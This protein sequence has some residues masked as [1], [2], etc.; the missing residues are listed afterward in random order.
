[1][2]KETIELSGDHERTIEAYRYLL[3]LTGSDLVSL[4]PKTKPNESKI[5]QR[6]DDNRIFVRRVLRFVFPELYADE[7]NADKKKTKDD[8][9]PGISLG[10]LVKILASLQR[11]WNSQPLSLDSA[12]ANSISREKK[13]HLLNI[14][15]STTPKER[16]D[17]G[18][19]EHPGELLLKKILENASDPVKGLG[20]EEIKDIYQ[21]FLRQQHTINIYNQNQAQLSHDELIKYTIYEYFKNLQRNLSEKFL[22][23]KVAEYLPKVKREISRIELQSGLKQIDFI[24]KDKSENISKKYL[25]A[26]LIRRLTFLVIDNQIIND[27]FPVYLKYYHIEAIRPL[28]LYLHDEDQKKGLLNSE[29]LDEDED[30]ESI[31]GLERQFVYKATVHFYIRIDSN[32]NC[33]L[34]STEVNT[35]I[36][37]ENRLEFIE[38]ITGVGSPISLVI[39]AINRVLLRDIPA[40]KDYFYI[41]NNKTNTVE[42][43]GSPNNNL[44]WSHTLVEICKKKDIQESI[45]SGKPYDQISSNNTYAHGEYCG[46]D[47]V[48]IATKAALYARLKAIQKTGVSPK[49][50]LEQLCSRVEEDNAVSISKNLISY[51]PFSL[52]AMEGFLDECLL[53]KK[54]WKRD[55]NY[56]FITIAKPWSMVA[57]EAHLNITEAYL[58]EGLHRVAKKYLALMESH[59]ED[60][61][62]ENCYDIIS[63]LMFARY[64][65]CWFRYYYLSD[66][67]DENCQFTDR[68]HVIDKALYHL[69][70]AE[71]YLKVRIEKVHCIDQTEQ[72]NFSPF[73]S[74][75]SKIYEYRA[76]IYM[77]FNPYAPKDISKSDNQ[78][79]SFYIKPI[80]LFE[81]ARI[82]AARDGNPDAYSYNSVYQS[83]CYLRLA[84]D[85][86]GNEKI[87][88][89][90]VDWAERLIEHAKLCYSTTGKKCYQDIKNHSGEIDVS[91]EID[92][93]KD[94]DQ[95]EYDSRPKIKIKGLPIIQ[96]LQPSDDKN[97]I[98]DTKYDVIHPDF[99]LLKDIHPNNESKSIY[100]F[101]PHSSVILFSMGLVDLCKQDSNEEE[102]S[103]SINTAIRKFYCSSVIAEDGGIKVEDNN[104]S[105]KLYL[106]RNFGN[107]ETD[108]LLQGFYIHRLTHFADFGKIFLIAC[109]IILIIDYFVKN[110]SIDSDLENEVKNAIELLVSND[111]FTRKIESHLD[112]KRYNGHFAAHYENLKKYH[113]DLIPNLS[114][115]SYRFNQPG[116]KPIKPNI[117]SIRNKVVMDFFSLLGG[118]PIDLITN[119]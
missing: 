108:G 119:S 96:E 56:N 89:S 85:C 70:E 64:N 45:K 17:I 81:K 61:N 46:F 76:K 26:S 25:A 115:L 92:E 78:H 27:D 101:G 105:N 47:L 48:E 42:A 59:I 16:L 65:L 114:N 93:V 52:T 2:F 35:T 69:D 30:I 51:Y 57:Y 86:K 94:V 28:P 23:N 107:G 8:S 116:Q 117:I 32:Y 21:Q 50:Y 112:Q 10:R 40:L 29:L 53:S 55:R 73:F 95:S 113:K 11:Y 31:S 41:V 118:H 100:L 79:K 4:N 74:I 83:W 19:E 82:Y 54:Y 24:R 5:A 110:D 75:L 91:T 80:K 20:S 72:T 38:E 12:G 34:K 43:T 97:N 99:S 109:K 87:N 6:W 77:F 90:Y 22:Q 37:N 111:N 39:A 98:K 13:I 36:N 14:F 84:F 88:L 63:D 62:I 7:K 60:P 103:K 66:L 18:L 1:M 71:K 33:K 15:T 58:N 102:I 44:C 106:D 68:P 3:Y 67:N 104:T 9:L 49:E